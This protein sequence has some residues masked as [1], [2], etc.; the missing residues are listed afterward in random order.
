MHPLSWIEELKMGW[1]PGLND[2]KESLIQHLEELMEFRNK[3]R[4]QSAQAD[5]FDEL[6]QLFEKYMAAK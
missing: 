3:E 2:H 1:R 4:Q 6:R 5:F